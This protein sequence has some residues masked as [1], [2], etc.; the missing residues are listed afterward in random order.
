M[1]QILNRKL[2]N[3]TNKNILLSFFKKMNSCML[4]I[5]V[6][7]VEAYDICIS[8]ATESGLRLYIKMET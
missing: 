2:F 4:V 3:T 6:R 8:F 7:I 5:H 1:K